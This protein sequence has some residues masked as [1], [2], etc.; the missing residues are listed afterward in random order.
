M[1]RSSSVKLVGTV[2]TRHT[3]SSGSSTKE[4]TKAIRVL[5]VLA[6]S[7][8]VTVIVMKKTV[9][10]PRSTIYVYL[11]VSCTFFL[12]CCILDL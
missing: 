12:V 5:V 2:G 8:T 10:G 6:Q 1:M 3:L 4:M 11:L 9:Q 7:P